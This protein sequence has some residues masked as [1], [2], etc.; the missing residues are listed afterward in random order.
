MTETM[1]QTELLIGGGTV[2]TIDPL[3]RIIEDGAVLVRGREIAAVGR[4]ADLRAANPDA[5][6]L[7]AAG[8]LV[9]PGFINTHNHLFQTLLK[10]LGDDRPLYRWLREVTGPAAAELTED[11]CETAALH[12]AVEAIRSGTTTIVDFMYAHPR[13]GLTEAVVRGLERAGVRAIVA[14]GF[15]TAGVDLG[16]PPALVER[17]EDALDDAADLVARFGSPDR[18]VRIGIA[19]CLLWMVDEETFRAARSFADRHRVLVTYHLAETSFEVEYA[20]RTYGLAETDLLE[21]VGFL[22]PDLLAVHCT[23]LDGDDIA[24]LAAHDVAVSHNP[25]SNMYLAAGIAPV[26]AMLERGLR[27]GLATDGPAS[28]NNQNMV[29]V[30]KATALLH[31]VAREDP[32]AMTALKVLELA[33]IE[34]ARAIGLGREI[35]SLEA[36]KRADVVVARP[37]GP[38]IE[39]V[40]DPVSAL[41]YAAVGTEVATVVV[42]G[43]VLMR[44]GRLT[45]LDE[46]AILDRS[47]R[48]AADLARRAGLRSPIGWRGR[49][50]P[51]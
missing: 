17:V 39:P 10:G 28:N 15:V 26:P 43:Q 4:T 2:V 46:V 50:Y 40:H 32:E 41:V 9:L 12:G 8:G 45:E 5:A 25:I 51:A 35:G 20:W 19:P 13:R 36:G 1:S 3:R 47:R 29:H 38:F 7:D 30:L 37:A 18:R 22:G 16:I 34:G 27:V 6:W 23:K 42:D 24:R 49:G 14:R 31:K 33:T 44:D 21:R 11:A 48:A